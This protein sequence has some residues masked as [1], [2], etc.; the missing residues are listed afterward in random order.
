MPVRA[1][2]LDMIGSGRSIPSLLYEPND[3]HKKPWQRGKRGSLCPKSVDMVS[4]EQ[5]LEGSLLE[6]TKR[7]AT[8]G[9]RAYCAQEHLAD[10][11]HGYPIGWEEVPP[12]IRAGLVEREGVSN[13]SVR[14]HW[15][16]DRT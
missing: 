4:A 9:V 5:L 11:W 12:K 15:R 14:Q 2:T 16:G 1:A 10:R 7:Y 3:K 6:G 13:R 8:D